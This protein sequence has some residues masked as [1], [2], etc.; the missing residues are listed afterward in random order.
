MNQFSNTRKIWHLREKLERILNRDALSSAKPR[1]SKVEGKHGVMIPK[2][3]VLEREESVTTSESTNIQS[4]LSTLH[5]SKKL[6][7]TYRD[8]ILAEATDQFNQ[9]MFLICTKNKWHQGF[10][11]IMCDVLLEE[12]DRGFWRPVK[13]MA[14]IQPANTS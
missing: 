9:G 7:V 4:V 14:R 3:V 5:C 11:I 10:H 13:F 1:Y 2:K 12:I 8:V 6:N